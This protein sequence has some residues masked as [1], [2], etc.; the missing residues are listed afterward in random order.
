M[1][2]EGLDIPMHKVLCQR[3]NPSPHKTQVS[4]HQASNLWLGKLLEHCA[5][6]SEPMVTEPYGIVQHCPWNISH[7]EELGQLA[8][9]TQYRVS[10]AGIFAE[11]RAGRNRWTLIYS[12]T[13]CCSSQAAGTLS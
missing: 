5:T 12:T 3:R 10:R 1:E 11:G 6:R 9:D 7:S 13:P 2:T 8:K 4:S